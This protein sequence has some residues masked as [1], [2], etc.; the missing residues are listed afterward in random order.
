MTDPRTSIDVWD[1][2]FNQTPTVLRWALGMLTMGVFTLAGILYRINRN[3]LEQITRQQK[4]DVKEM[5]DRMDR[6]ENK[7]DQ[8]TA[9]MN[10]HLLQIAHN[11]SRL[12]YR[13]NDVEGQ[14]YDDQNGDHTGGHL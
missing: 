3:D 2:I 5:H 11:T 14:R 4:A 6:F 7:L 13:W 9:E 10:R 12:P 8:T 1:A